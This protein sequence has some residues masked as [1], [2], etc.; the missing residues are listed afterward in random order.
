MLKLKKKSNSIIVALAVIIVLALCF[1]QIPK[2][3]NGTMMVATG[4][5]ETATVDY[6]LQYYCNFIL[7]TYVKG[8][9]IV[10]GVEYIDQ[11]SMFEQFP[12]VKDNELIPS[13]WWQVESSVPYNMTFVRS[14]CTDVTSAQI[15]RINVLDIVLDKGVCEIH[16]MYSDESNAVNGSVSGIS[17]WGPAQ[18]AEEAAQIAEFFGYHAP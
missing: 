2:R 11:Y 7:P 3:V 18:N 8:T 14:D 17:L 12:S 9:L 4:T 13:N 15:N 16:F 10:D 1:A 6:N 5:G